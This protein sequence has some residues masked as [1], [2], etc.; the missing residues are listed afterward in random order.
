MKRVMPVLAILLLIPGT[1][2][3]SGCSKTPDAPLT[4]T[5]QTNANTAAPSKT[6]KTTATGTLS[7]SPNPIKVCDNSK[8]GVTTLTWNTMGATDVEVRVWKPDGDLFAK[9]GPSGSW[10][11]GKW[12]NN[13]TV[14]YLQDVSGGKPLTSEYTITTLTANVTNAGCP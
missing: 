2:A 14:F 9:S 5:S 7:A 13:G 4:N 6:S 10:A 11:T 1:F 3:I 12:V 8:T